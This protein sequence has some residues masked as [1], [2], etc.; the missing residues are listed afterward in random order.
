MG[1]TLNKNT[2]EVDMDVSPTGETYSMFLFNAKS[3]VG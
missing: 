3:L 2:M 1:A